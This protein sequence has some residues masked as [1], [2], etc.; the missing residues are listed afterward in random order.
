M[1]Q[2]LLPLLL[3][4]ADAVWRRRYILCVPVL[5]LLPITVLYLKFGPRPYV[6]KSLLL[7]QENS[8]DNP[9]AGPKELPGFVN[10]QER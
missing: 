3:A 4:V 9:L 2:A 7:M 10:M 6:A 5:V 8:R 1:K